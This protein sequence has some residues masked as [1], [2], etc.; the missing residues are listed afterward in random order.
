MSKREQDV[1]MPLQSS[2]PDPRRHGAVPAAAALVPGAHA[3]PRRHRDVDAAPGYT[4]SGD[5]AGHL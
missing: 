3:M 4:P 5:E 2:L 1:P